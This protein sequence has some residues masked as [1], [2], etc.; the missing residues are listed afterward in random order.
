MTVAVDLDAKTEELLRNAAMKNGVELDEY[1]RSLIDRDLRRLTFDERLAPVRKS[2]VESE[3]TEEELD[4]FM[5]GILRQVRRERRE[6]RS[7]A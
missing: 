5:N 6:A 1:L 3:M 4:A 2:V 7:K